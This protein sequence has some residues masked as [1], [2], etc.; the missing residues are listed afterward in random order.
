MD[1]W[2]IGSYWIHHH[3]ARA[4]AWNTFSDSTLKRDF[5]QLPNALEMLS[6][7]NGYYYHWKKGAADTS[8]QVGVMAQEIQRVL[9]EAVSTDSD[10]ILSVDYG[11]LTALLIE[12]NQAQQA[13][14][15]FLEA[16]N[17]EIQTAF[18][19]LKEEKNSQQA[20]LKASFEAR[21]QALEALL[22]PQR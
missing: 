11:K 5:Q 6:Q 7:I 3:Q 12:A 20:E 17:A 8:R 16:K 10:G 13:Q 14:I 21:L 4:N 9:P 18:E 1:V 2:E 19:A 15:Q 22:T